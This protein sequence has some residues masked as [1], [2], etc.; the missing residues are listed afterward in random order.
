VVGLERADSLCDTLNPHQPFAPG[1][2]VFVVGSGDA[3]RAVVMLFGGLD[4]A[5]DG[6]T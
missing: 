4:S 6:S 2:V 3:L 1:D 5:H